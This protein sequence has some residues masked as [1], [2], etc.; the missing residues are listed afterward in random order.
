MIGQ[1]A[2]FEVMEEEEIE[3]LRKRQSDFEKMRNAELAEVQRLE[4]EAKR[5]D[6]EKVRP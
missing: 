5:Y 6:D 2:M 1:V 4:S 3:A